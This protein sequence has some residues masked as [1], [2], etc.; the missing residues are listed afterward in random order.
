MSRLERKWTYAVHRSRSNFV[1][2]ALDSESATRK[3]RQTVPLR[4]FVGNFRVLA[5]CA[6]ERSRYPAL[7]VSRRVSNRKICQTIDY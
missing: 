7:R 6:T 4:K 5:H 2:F 1:I 3:T